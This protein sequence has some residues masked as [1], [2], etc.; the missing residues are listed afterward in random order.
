MPISAFNWLDISLRDTGADGAFSFFSLT[1][2]KRPT[3]QAVKLGEKGGKV[4]TMAKN[5]WRQRLAFTDVYIYTFNEL[6]SQSTGQD[7]KS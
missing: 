6:P 2:V 4:S 3:N 1:N 7:E 5:K